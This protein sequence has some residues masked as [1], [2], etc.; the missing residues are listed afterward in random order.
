MWK[1]EES[2][3][4]NVYSYCVIASQQ[5]V[6]L[7]D[8]LRLFSLRLQSL[9]LP[10]TGQRLTIWCLANLNCPQKNPNLTSNLI[11]VD[12]DVCERKSI[13][14]NSP[15]FTWKTDSSLVPFIDL[16]LCTHNP[17]GIPAI[18]GV[19]HHRGSPV[20]PFRQLDTSNARQCCEKEPLQLAGCQ[21]R[22]WWKGGK[23][24]S[25]TD[26][27]PRRKDTGGA[28]SQQA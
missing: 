25:F 12:D 18:K 8:F 23:R 22:W 26:T 17:S 5:D 4:F 9:H 15:R 21:N 24:E 27:L 13:F 10:P 11:Y 3:R 16:W 1:K 14:L 6:C 28:T 2:T 19:P 20:C 7:F